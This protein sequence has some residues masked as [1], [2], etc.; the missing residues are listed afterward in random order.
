MNF[1]FKVI[2]NNYRGEIFEGSACRKLIENSD[3]LL[4]PESYNDPFLVMP[5]VVVLR[6]YNKAVHDCFSTAKISPDT[7]R[8][9]DP[10][11]FGLWSEQAGE[12]IHQEFLWTFGVKANTSKSA[13]LA[14]G[15][16]HPYRDENKKPFVA[17]LINLE[18]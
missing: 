2:A 12:S 5:Y 13:I 16:S 6:N 10:R 8:D 15:I 17:N 11:G 4:D 1:T 18:V 9:I 3:R 7:K 14:N